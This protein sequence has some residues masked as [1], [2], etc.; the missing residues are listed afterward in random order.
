M[1]RTSNSTQSNQSAS[2]EA[3]AI[4]RLYTELALRPDQEFGWGKGKENARA[5]G[6]EARWLD[7]LP[8]ILWES[9]AAVGNPFSAAPLQSGDFVVDLGCGAG[10]D[11]CI[12][13]LSLGDQ[14]RVIGIDVTP[15]MIEKAKRI[16]EVVGLANVTFQVADMA[17]V[18]VA[19][20]WADVVISNGAINLTEHKAC[21]FR[22]ACRILK[23]GGRFQLAD[24][25]R[26]SASEPETGGS[27]AGCVAGTVEPERYLE[28]LKGAGFER[29]RLMALTGYKTAPNTA[30]AVFLA[31]KK[32]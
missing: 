32:G 17:A 16:A 24:M 6:Y 19:D 22:E 18:P 29:A 15:A 10:A 14:G 30:G 5:L 1:S 7:T 26:V 25:V 9:A 8:E 23:P 27:W 13:A 11:A 12:A 21:V 20:A 28:M 2:C 4:L 31:Y 3:G